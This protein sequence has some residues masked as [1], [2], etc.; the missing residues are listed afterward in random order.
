MVPLMDSGLL[1]HLRG[2]NA[3]NLRDL[4]AKSNPRR[5][6]SPNI[7]GTRC[8]SASVEYVGFKTKV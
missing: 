6:S 7:G 5:D 8:G 3:N 2:Q 1:R 4:S